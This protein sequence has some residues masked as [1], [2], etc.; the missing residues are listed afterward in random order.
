MENKTRPGRVNMN[1]EEIPAERT[2]CDMT[3]WVD[4][5]QDHE[6]DDNARLAEIYFSRPDLCFQ[7]FLRTRE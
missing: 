2:L 1:M 4:V 7:G 5:I 6:P 3:V